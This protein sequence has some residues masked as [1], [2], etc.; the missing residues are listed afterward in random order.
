MTLCFCSETHG[1]KQVTWPSLIPVEWAGIILPQEGVVNFLKTIESNKKSKATKP[2]I[3]S[4]KP[5]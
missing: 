3:V 1:P 2:E 5:G 4:E